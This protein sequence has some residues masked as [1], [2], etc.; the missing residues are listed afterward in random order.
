MGQVLVVTS[1][2]GGTGKT[3]LCAGIAA[4]LSQ[5]GKTVLCIDADIGL[6]NLDLALGMADIATVAF[7]EVMLERMPLERAPAHPELPGLQLLTAPASAEP[8]DE[9]A[10]GQL[11]DRARGAYDWVLVD[12]PAGIGG[13]FRLSACHADRA[14]VV[15]TADP[16]SLRDAGRAAQLLQQIGLTKSHLAVNR[17][18]RRLFQKLGTTIDDMMDQIGLPLLGLVPEDPNV[19]L[20]AVSGKALLCYTSRNA[21]IAMKNMARRLMYE[22]VP[23]MRLR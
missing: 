13:G 6:R 16:A 9:D 1:A 22:T 12:A 4:A 23:L 20:A 8:I 14:L 5:L 10:F 15:S 11:L 19:V 18:N 7:S 17:V 2:K 3:T 21:A